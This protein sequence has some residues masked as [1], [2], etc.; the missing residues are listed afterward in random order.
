MDMGF[1]CRKNA[2]FPGA[3]KIGAAISGPRI[4]DKTFYGHEEKSKDWRV[5]VVKALG[6]RASEILVKT[7]VAI[8][9]AGWRR[10]SVRESLCKS[11]EVVRLPRERADL[12]GSPANFRGSPGNFRGSLGKNFQGTPGLL[13]SSTVRELSGKLPKNFRGSLGNFRGSPGTSQKLGVA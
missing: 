2:F 11:G 3:H 6:S 4:A 8:M 5:R 1:S 7:P 10:V 12:R 13:Q 9:A